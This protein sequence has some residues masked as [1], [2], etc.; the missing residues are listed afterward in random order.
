VLA[1][2]I[3]VLAAAADAD[4]VTKKATPVTETATKGNVRAELSYVK[5]VEGSG[6]TSYRDLR[7]TIS[8]DGQVVDTRQPPRSGSFNLLWPGSS[9]KNSQSVHVADLDGDNEPEVTVDL[10]TGGAHCCRML[11]AYRWNGTA[12]AAQQMETGSSPYSQRDL[13][14]DGRPEWVT[15]D[16]RFEYLFTSFAGSGVPLRIYDYR[17]GNFVE[18]TGKFP[19]PVRKDAAR[20]W[21]IYQR[22]ASGND[23]RGFLAAWAADMCVLGEGAKV[24]PTLDAAYRQGKL[25]GQ[26][27]LTGLAYVRKLR[28]K[29]RAFGYLP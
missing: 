21:R 28:Q 3:A 12:Y 9:W 6:F 7:L 18:V 10:Y 1:S 23:N 2:A 22:S 8:R 24:W 19:S 25:S 5:V 17:D 27:G 13:D 29:L 11:Y 15:A 4:A 16:P 14:A 26:G 20:W